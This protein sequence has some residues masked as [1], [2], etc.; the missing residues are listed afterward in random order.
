MGYGQGIGNEKRKKWNIERENREES[1][2]AINNRKNTEDR[3]D[4]NGMKRWVGERKNNKGNGRE[5]DE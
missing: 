4:V 1:K 3:R 2:G 5:R